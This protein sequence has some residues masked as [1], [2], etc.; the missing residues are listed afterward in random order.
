[1][2]SIACASVVVC[3]L[4]LAGC[5]A[6]RGT[7]VA[8]DSYRSHR[9]LL[10]AFDRNTGDVAGFSVGI[11][12]PGRTLTL[13]LPHGSLASFSWGE[14][15]ESTLNQSEREW[16]EPS[17]KA[18]MSYGT[19]SVTASLD[20]MSP[21]CMI[22][23][24]HGSANKPTAIAVL[25]PT[26][27]HTSPGVASMATKQFLGTRGELE[28]ILLF[29]VEHGEPLDSYID[30]GR[31]EYAYRVLQKS[32]RTAE[33]TKMMRA[34]DQ[35]RSAI[36]SSVLMLVGDPD[37]LRSFHRLCL[38]TKGDLQVQLVDL[39]VDSPASEQAMDTI[40]TL[41]KR[42]QPSSGYGEDRRYRLVE[43]LVG[44]YPYAKR[45]EAMADIIRSDTGFGKEKLQECLQKRK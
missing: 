19:L 45:I 7:H 2:N 34:D 38:T 42:G 24:G 20:L 16:P 12:K 43:A 40:V 3:G 41:L 1:M 21:A 44:Q 37:G 36:A 4:L 25:V 31:V 27:A 6:P 29:E 30:F 26:G 11:V 15:G 22:I 32:D 18:T 8:R 10:W 5:I 14:L 33:W 35:Y 13:T 28:D 39:L 9:V 17:V 23:P